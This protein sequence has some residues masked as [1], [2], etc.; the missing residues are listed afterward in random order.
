LV[1]VNI[2]ANKNSILNLDNR[3]LNALGEI[4]YGIYMYHMLVIFGI[5]LILKKHLI[6]WSGTFATIIFYFI[7]TGAVI[8][9]SLL[10]KRIFEDYFLRLKGKFRNKSIHRA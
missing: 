4:S 3:I 5:I 2:S 10:S 8:I 1:I 6:V 9:I 7:L